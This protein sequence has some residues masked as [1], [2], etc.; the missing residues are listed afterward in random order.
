MRSSRL[1]RRKYLTLQPDYV[2]T[3]PCHS[4]PSSLLSHPWVLS[5][6]LM[7]PSKAAPVSCALHRLAAPRQHSLSLTCDLGTPSAGPPLVNTASRWPVTSALHRL[8]A[9]RQHSLS[10]TC[11]LCTPSTG[12]PLV[13]TASRWPV[14]SALHR[15]AAPR[16]HG[17]SLTRPAAASPR[18]QHEPLSMATPTTRVASPCTR[19]RPCTRLHPITTLCS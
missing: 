1:R 12:R 18:V 4:C 14:T 19:L 3:C 7:L 10:L 5:P 6:A 13:N 8:A 15:P 17:L 2:S 16:Q 11:D 9:P